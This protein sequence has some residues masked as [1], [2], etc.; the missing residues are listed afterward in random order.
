MA[1]TITSATQLAQIGRT[2]EY[3]G[4]GSYILGNN[5]TISGEWTT[6]LEAN[7]LTFN[8]NG[9]RISTL[10]MPLF[11][12]LYNATV[13]NLTLGLDIDTTGSYFP[14]GYGAAGGLAQTVSGCTFTNITTE[15]RIA[16]RSA[17]GGMIGDTNRSDFTD[18]T[19]YATIYCTRDRAGGI[20]S[21]GSE[22]NFIRCVNHGDVTTSGALADPH[23]QGLWAGGIAGIVQTLGDYPYLPTFHQ[24]VDCTNDGSIQAGGYGGGIAGWALAY[25]PNG[26]LE[27]RN[28]HNHG[29]VSY[30]PY[31]PPIGEGNQSFGGIVG[32]MLYG[33]DIY[34]CTNDAPISGGRSV[35]GITGSA[36]ME[37]VYEDYYG[38]GWLTPNI[39]RCYNSGPVT[40][41][42]PAS[43]PIDN[44]HYQYAG[45]ISGR[46]RHGGIIQENRNT[47]A[48]SSNA[49]NTGGIVGDVVASN[50]GGSINEAPVTGALNTGGIAGAVD[51]QLVMYV[52]PTLA[53]PAS[54]VVRLTD[55]GGQIDAMENKF[56]PMPVPA[57]RRV[58]ALPLATLEAYAALRG[59]TNAQSA[60]ITA[61]DNNTGG[62]AGLIRNGTLVQDNK[63]CGDMISTGSVVGGIVGRAEQT[64]LTSPN[65]EI[66][67]NFSSP[68]MVSGVTSVYRVLGASTGQAPVS[69]NNTQVYPNV[70][71]TGNNTADG[72]LMYSNQPVAENDPQLGATLRQGANL[73]CPPG[74]RPEPCVGCAPYEPPV[75]PKPPSCP[76]CPSWFCW[77][78]FS[79]CCWPRVSCCPSGQNRP[80]IPNVPKPACGCMQKRVW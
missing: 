47:G 44:D 65:N 36:G 78:P 11:N 79:M 6:L 60:R 61:T 40:L 49:P 45:G 74:E 64:V 52:E 16:G 48:V 33:G 51:T 3:P 19:N 10:T 1:I 9:H 23:S 17:I 15:G 32:N 37:Y 4:N 56:T 72:G 29:P 18:C 71:L 7:G 14:G 70:L 13:S 54:Y 58:A 67:N 50:V 28:C 80:Q 30:S 20:T 12:R 68:L 62:I 22:C 25:A 59:N 21:L 35:G 77:W 38:Y 55:T 34:D 46:L 75:P 69:L 5:I 43:L 41:T 63:N 66:T 27:I 31:T 2:Q 26:M 24:M 53:N 8:G 39:V 42:A 57:T 76:C 73:V